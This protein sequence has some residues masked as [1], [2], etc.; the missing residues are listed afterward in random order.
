M[1]AILIIVLGAVVVVFGITWLSH[2][3]DFPRLAAP[4]PPS[5]KV[6][7]PQIKWLTPP[8]ING[9]ENAWGK[10]NLPG[11]S[12]SEFIPLPSDMKTIEVRG[13]GH[14]LEDVVNGGRIVGF[15]V[16]ND[17]PI[18]GTFVYAFHPK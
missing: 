1:K 4:A 17:A 6:T 8:S 7:G 3:L 14:R 11:N 13:N 5:D 16:Y 9:P 10:L 12:K 2:D 15:Y 18:F